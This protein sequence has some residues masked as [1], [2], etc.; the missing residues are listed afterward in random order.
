[1][2]QP[3]ILFTNFGGYNYVNDVGYEDNACYENDVNN[4]YDYN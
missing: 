1:M 3:F 4:Y 2:E